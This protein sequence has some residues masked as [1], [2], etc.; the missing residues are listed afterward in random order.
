VFV[1]PGPDAGLPQ[2]TQACGYYAQAIEAV[3]RE[4]PGVSLPAVGAMLR[5][6]ADLLSPDS[7]CSP[8][9]YLPDGSPVAEDIAGE[10]WRLR[11]VAATV[12]EIARAA[13]AEEAA[14]DDEDD[15]ERAAVTDA[16]AKAFRAAAAITLDGPFGCADPAELAEA[17]DRDEEESSDG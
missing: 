11:D 13:E 12:T 2:E 6:I 3:E 17:A 5:H 14:A 10:A 1:L 15:G 8:A 4:S 16:V 9:G 7:D